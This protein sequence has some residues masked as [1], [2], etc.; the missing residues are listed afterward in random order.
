MDTQQTLTILL[1]VAASGYLLRRGW[2]SLRGKGNGC[3]ACSECPVEPSEENMPVRKELYT[4]GK[5]K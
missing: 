4:L 2:L 3:G 1:A 5:P